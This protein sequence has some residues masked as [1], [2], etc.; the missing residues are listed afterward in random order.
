MIAAA[1]LGICLLLL[2]ATPLA[3]AP[4]IEAEVESELTLYPVRP[5]GF[6]VLQAGVV[7]VT[8]HCDEG[9]CAL[10]SAQV[11]RIYNRDRIKVQTI[12]LGGTPHSAWQGIDLRDGSGNALRKGADDDSDTPTWEITLAPDERKTLLFTHQRELDQGE[13]LR[14]RWDTISLTPWQSV[15]SLR[16]MLTLPG[17]TPAGA[18]YALEPEGYR[19]DGR[20]VIWD[21]GT[22]DH[23]PEHGITLLS[24]ETWQRLQAMQ[25]EARHYDLAQA[26][27]ALYDVAQSQG[28][29]MADPFPLVVGELLAAIEADP[30]AL[31]PRLDLAAL[32]RTRSDDPSATGLNYLLLAAEQLQGAL[33]SIKTDVHPQRN[34]VAELLAQTYYEA[35]L[36]AQRMGDTAGGLLYLTKAERVPVTVS[37]D[38][39][40]SREDM[41]LQWALD[42]AEKGMVSQA[43]SEMRDHLSPGLEDAFLR[44]APPISAARTQVYISPT[45]RRATYL[46][47]PYAPVADRTRTRL[48]ELG[49]ALAEIDGVTVTIHESDSAI[50]EITVEIAARYRSEQELRDLAATIRRAMDGDQDLLAALLTSPWHPEAGAAQREETPWSERYLYREQIDLAALA[51]TWEREAHYVQWRLIELQSALPTEERERLEH[52]LALL[53][54]REQRQVWQRLPSASYWVYHLEW[55]TASAEEGKSWMLSWQ[56]HRDLAVEIV[57]YRWPFLVRSLGL[58]ALIGLVLGLVF[59]S[60]RRKVEPTHPS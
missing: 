26:Y 47:T 58:V 49:Q 54:L 31:A 5:P 7:E 3:A 10:R 11:Y 29:A 51:D 35:A 2:M 33:D 44:Y 28:I 60:S 20:Q 14:W 37:T 16:V 4:A 53:A 12:L 6:I 52:N 42:M 41:A 38:V 18:I 27:L 25:D 13:F 55:G 23:Y 21:Y 45:Q 24:P 30:D 1:I 56:Q 32:Y 43:L 57:H 36:R 34:V 40:T 22:L 17:W 39:S 50:S 48:E 19:S 59:V 46:V 15:G 8:I 9:R